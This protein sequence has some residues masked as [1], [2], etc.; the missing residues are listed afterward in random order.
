[1]EIINRYAVITGDG[2]IVGIFST[3]AMAENFIKGFQG[4]FTS[5][6]RYYKIY[7]DF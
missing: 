2:K 6:L 7:T 5:E 3:I 1:M 4:D